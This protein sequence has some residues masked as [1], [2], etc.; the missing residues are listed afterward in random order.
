MTT[1]IEED[2]RY[3]FHEGDDFCVDWWVLKDSEGRTIHQKNSIGYEEWWEYNPIGDIIR[4]RDSQGYEEWNEFDSVG[5]IIHMKY[6][7]SGV[8][9][10]NERKYE[11]DTN[12]NCTY[13]KGTNGF[14]WRKSS[15]EPL[16]FYDSF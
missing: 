8:V 2:P 9:D 11:Y 1:N 4:Y 7:Y 12:G 5:N 14:E 16:P 13:I 6:K 10:W 15:P 3:E